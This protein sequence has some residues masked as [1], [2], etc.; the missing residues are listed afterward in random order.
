MARINPKKSLYKEAKVS[1]FSIVKQIIFV[2][3]GLSLLLLFT[4][5]NPS[6]L[7]LTIFFV[8]GIIF[9]ALNETQQLSSANPKAQPN[10]NYLKQIITLSLGLFLLGLVLLI[11]KESTNFV[12]V[13]LTSFKVLCVS[14]LTSITIEVTLNRLVQRTNNHKL[15]DRSKE[16]IE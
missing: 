14:T 11:Q 8:S 7:L 4:K 13:V 3:M 16:E 9:V 12:D 10:R 5:G 15:S 1:L 6:G 2:G